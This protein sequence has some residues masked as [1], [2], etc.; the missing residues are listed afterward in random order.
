MDRVGFQEKCGM[1]ILSLSQGL[2]MG[3]FDSKQ[4]SIDL[5]TLDFK[6]L[7]MGLSH[8]WEAQ[9]SRITLGFT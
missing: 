9:P 5:L 2:P 3:N 8:T 1:S 4:F 6:P 7:R